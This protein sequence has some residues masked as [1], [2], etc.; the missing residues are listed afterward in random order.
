MMTTTAPATTPPRRAPRL[1]LRQALHQ[2]LYQ[3]LCQLLWLALACAAR[4]ASAAAPAPVGSTAE[5]PLL[6]ER[7]PETEA[8]ERPRLVL[9]LKGDAPASA[10]SLTLLPGA[11][12]TPGAGK[13]AESNEQ[14]QSWPLLQPGSPVTVLLGTG[15]VGRTLWHGQ[16]RYQQGG[17]AYSLITRF[18]TLVRKKGEAAAPSRI[19]YD[20]SHMDLAARYIEVQLVGGGATRGEVT[21]IGEDGAPIGSGSATFS[22]AQQRAGAWLRLP[23]VARPGREAT[24]V[25]RLELTLTD[26]SGAAARITLVPWS[27]SVPHEEVT[28]ATARWDIA[29]QERSKLD[30]SY[31]K[32]LA[33]L[34]QVRD[35][36]IAP[37]L[38]VTGHTDSR[39]GDGY[40]LHL[41]QQRARA[42]AGYL[43]QRGLT[44]PVLFAGAGER[45]PAV[46]T[47][48]NTDEPQ[49]RRADYVL[50]AGPPPLP[51]GVAWTALHAAAAASPSESP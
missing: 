32:I 7:F 51:A 34:A 11:S 23:W 45:A 5:Q 42:I 28:F 40:N 50:S 43:L 49:N 21:A 17:R 41:S 6:I 4:P 46:R 25:L 13:A 20:Y 14:K 47:A 33:I 10:V 1:L 31:D 29:S 8:P 12:D 24:R 9:T 38:Y 16:I 15:K 44:I 18:E 36:G 3:V 37:R 27:V 26:R 19:L 22:G 35:K 39:G 48:D 2:P 30:S